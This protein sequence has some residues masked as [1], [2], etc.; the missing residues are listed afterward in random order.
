MS[1]EEYFKVILL[2]LSDPSKLNVFVTKFSKGFKLTEQRT[3]ELLSK[4]PVVI[5]KK[6]TSE[7]ADKMIDYVNG[8]GGRARKESLGAPGAESA[9]REK[10]PPVEP[11][12]PPEIKE[13]K[14]PPPVE[15]KEEV[16]QEIKEE[17]K[18]E[19]MKEGG[20]ATAEGAAF[21]SFPSGEDLFT[22]VEVKK[23]SGG[24]IKRF[25]DQEVDLG[26]VS[27]VEVGQSGKDPISNGEAADPSAIDVPE[28][29]EGLSDIPPPMEIAK[30]EKEEAAE[31]ACPNCG[32]VQERGEECIKCG[33][34]FS[35][36]EKVE[37]KPSLVIMDPGR[38]SSGGKGLLIFLAVLIIGGFIAFPYLKG[39]LPFFKK[40]ET[41]AGDLLPRGGKDDKA[42]AVK[43]VPRYSDY[44]TDLRKGMEWREVQ[45]QAGQYIYMEEPDPLLSDRT[46]RYLDHHGNKVFNGA[47]KLVFSSDEILLRVEKKDVPYPVGESFEEFKELAEKNLCYFKKGK[48]LAD[49]SQEWNVPPGCIA[50][51]KSG[52]KRIIVSPA[53]L[54]IESD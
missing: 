23:T 48:V 16:R 3:K 40:G 43:M 54:I 6:T 53:G 51:E 7:K 22:E 8:I 36:I 30:E 21:D 41:K 25:E 33:V 11:P 17:V 10:A 37:E 5:N 31:F 29:E 1:G 38:R 35:R 46:I 13:E 28:G 4:A 15:V 20:E 50:P 52:W 44:R 19:S 27:S 2:G 14:A 26:S 49:N 12:K 42:P 18:E 47:W 32:Q 9:E 45:R 34:V 39:H 24:Q